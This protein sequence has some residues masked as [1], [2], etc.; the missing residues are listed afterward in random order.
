MKQSTK[1]IAL[2]IISILMIIFWIILPFFW[3]NLNWAQ[4]II[5]GIFGYI[6]KKTI[7]GENNFSKFYIHFIFY[8]SVL[9]SVTYALLT[10]KEPEISLHFLLI[11]VGFI[12]LV[13]V[14]FSWKEL[15]NKKNNKIIIKYIVFITILIIFFGYVFAYL[16]G[17]DKTEDPNK[18]NLDSFDYIYYSGMNFY[19]GNYGTIHPTQT[20]LIR[21]A[22]LIEVIFSFIIHGIVLSQIMSKTESENLKNIAIKSHKN[23]KNNTSKPIRRA[24]K[25]SKK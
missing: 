20:M 17:F 19:T 11:G 15:N 3:S 8:S 21:I 7:T 12:Y 14:F 22:S 23:E 24:P 5:L 10:L 9:L 6:Y 25:N 16:S 13:A 2:L 4:I 18:P 1:F